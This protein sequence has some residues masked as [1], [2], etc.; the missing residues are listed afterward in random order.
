MELA[1]L[2]FCIVGPLFL[3][4]C[5][6][7]FFVTECRLLCACLNLGFLLFGGIAMLRG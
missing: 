7:C 2:H 6:M 3:S 1:I 4:T 5:V